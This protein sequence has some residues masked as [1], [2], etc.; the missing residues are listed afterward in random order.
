MDTIDSRVETFCS[1]VCALCYFT[2]PCQ[3]F[4]SKTIATWK[5]K[6]R[7]SPKRTQRAFSSESRRIG[8][9]VARLLETFFLHVG[10]PTICKKWS[11]LPSKTGLDCNKWNSRRAHSVDT[12]LQL[13]GSVQHRF[14]RVEEGCQD[15]LAS[16]WQCWFIIRSDRDH[17]GSALEGSLS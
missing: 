7:R 11:L 5:G 9:I 3:V 12:P 13:P 10:S 16:P 1:I 17:C 2:R 8:I 4:I 14:D 15:T 6:V